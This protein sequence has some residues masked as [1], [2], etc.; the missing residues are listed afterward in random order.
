MLPHLILTAASPKWDPH[1]DTLQHS[2]AAVTNNSSN[3]HDFSP[4][5]QWQ[6]LSISR[7]VFHSQRLL[8]DVNASSS[9]FLI[10][11]DFHWTHSMTHCLIV[12]I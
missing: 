2:E 1:S 4:T 12:I 5:M 9:V 6:V 8:A 7:V 11:P 10:S 3:L